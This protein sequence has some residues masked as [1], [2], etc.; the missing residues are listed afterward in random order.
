MAI[1]SAVV[2]IH[3]RRD[4]DVHAGGK[5]LQHEIHQILNRYFFNRMVVIQNKGKFTGDF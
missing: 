4:N 1:N 5:I 3:T 2:G